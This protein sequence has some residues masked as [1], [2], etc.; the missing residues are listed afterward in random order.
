MATA[1]DVVQAFNALPQT[2]KTLAAAQIQE[3]APLPRPPDKV[4]GTLWIMVVAALVFGFAGGLVGIFVLIEGDKP[5]E[6]IV[7]IVTTVLGFLGG[8]LAPSPAAK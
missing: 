1:Q 2:E 4:V 6:V 5:T 7:P 8:L 3:V